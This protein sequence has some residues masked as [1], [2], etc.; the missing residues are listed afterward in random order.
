MNKEEIEMWK[1]GVMEHCHSISV[2]AKDR[3]TIKKMMVDH[4]SQFFEWD[5]IE[6]D[7]NFNTI[8]MAWEYSTDPII[9]LDKIKELGMDFIIGHRF[10]KEL[11][12]G[13]TITVY[14]F[15]LP[16]EGVIT[17]S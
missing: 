11:G 2:I 4:L 13:V 10:F 17:E 6:F 14:P 7:K 8:T 9:K 1:D 12:D 16:K 15:G 3:K 5:V